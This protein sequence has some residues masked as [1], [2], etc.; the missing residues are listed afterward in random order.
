MKKSM[1]IQASLNA[2]K[3]IG[4]GSP[5]DTD[6]ETRVPRRGFHQC[7]SSAVTASCLCSS[8]E[9][10]HQHLVQ[11]CFSVC[12]IH[13]LAMKFTRAHLSL[14]IC[15]FSCLCNFTACSLSPE[16]CLHLALTRF[17]ATHLLF[18]HFQFW[19]SRVDVARARL[20]CDLDGN[21]TE[22]LRINIS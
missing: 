9:N 8:C 14:Q 4:T 7:L 16:P 20:R 11:I 6:G 18:A 13:L 5:A 21:R 22:K 10:R 15:M 12:H 19:P 1:H 3:H 2:I 17:L